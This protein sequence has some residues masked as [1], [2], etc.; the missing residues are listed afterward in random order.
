MRAPRRAAGR[1]AG[2]DEEQQRRR[3]LAARL[4]L[5]E[6]GIAAARVSRGWPDDFIAATRRPFDGH[7]R[8]SNKAI[9]F[10]R[11]E[12]VTG[13]VPSRAGCLA[14]ARVRAAARR[15]LLSK[16]RRGSRT[17][18]S[19]RGHQPKRLGARG[20]NGNGRRSLAFARRSARRTDSAQPW[21][22]SEHQ[23]TGANGRSDRQAGGH[24]FE[25]STA[26]RNPC[27]TICCVASPVDEDG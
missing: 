13:R 5:C 23:R 7:V 25:P 8:V 22:L 12:P 4:P 6:S 27:K 14:S 16:P 9:A 15:R 11:Y 17:L 1:V 19:V 3:T 26:H 2:L 21:R 24:W 18:G 20:N 10:P